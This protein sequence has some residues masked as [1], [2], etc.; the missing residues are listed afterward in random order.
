MKFRTN[1]YL[2]IMASIVSLTFSCQRVELTYDDAMEYDL[3]QI[4]MD[5]SYSGISPQGATVVFYPK[6]GNT[7]IKVLMTSNYQQVKLKRGTYSIIA[8][9]N[10]FNDFDNIVFRNTSRYETIEAY[11][12][13]IARP[14]K[15]KTD[16]GLFTNEMDPLA[17]AKLDNF[18]VTQDMVNASMARIQS[19]KSGSTSTSLTTLT[20]RPRLC[21]IPISVHVKTTGIQN[22]KYA[23]G[24]LTG[25]S[26]GILLSSNKLTANPISHFFDFDIIPSVSD[27]SKGEL[28]TNIT[29]F[30][31][32]QEIMQSVDE[33]TILIN[34]TL[35]TN[36]NPVVSTWKSQTKTL[37]YDKK[38]KLEIY[39]PLVD[40]VT[41]FDEIFDVNAEIVQTTSKISI[42]V[43]LSM[44]TIPNVTPEGGGNSGFNPDVS[45]WGETN[46][47]PIS[48]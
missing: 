18:E 48:I 12:K 25:M 20:V 3:V 1:I 14:A 43:D 17:I 40:N 44:V 36:D 7:P 41:T 31:F 19:T 21:I 45:D 35:T 38:L 29:T 47:I 33:P 6:N 13:P 37:Y 16:N 2:F 42:V 27:Y 46:K 8:I 9:N 39:A 10:S 4:E 22:I 23:Q 34:R 32:P 28:V 5:W 26:E 15:L 11:A 30:G 24:V